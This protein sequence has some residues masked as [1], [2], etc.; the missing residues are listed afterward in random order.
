M[1][2]CENVL[3]SAAEKIKLSPFGDLTMR[4]VLKWNRLPQEIGRLISPSQT[5]EN[6]LGRHEERFRWMITPSSLRSFQPR[7][8]LLEKL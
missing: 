2:S 8:P 5:H 1:F 3:V 4:M 7:N 6:Y